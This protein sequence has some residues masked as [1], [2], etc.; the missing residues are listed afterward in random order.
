MTATPNPTPRPAVTEADR[1]KARPAFRQALEFW[2]DGKHEQARGMVDLG[3]LALGRRLPEDRTDERLAEFTDRVTLSHDERFLVL[4]DRE[5]L[6]VAE[7]STGFVLGLR[8]HDF[9]GTTVSP[10]VSPKGTYVVAPTA[11]GFLVYETRGLLPMS[12]VLTRYD[13]PLAF[14]DERHVVTVRLGKAEIPTAPSLEPR[15]HVLRE[16]TPESPRPLDAPAGPL[17]G[18]QA[19]DELIVVDITSGKIEKTLKLTMPPDQGLLRRVAA[20]PKGELC[21]DAQD[22]DRFAFNP[23]PIGRRVVRLQIQA[24]VISAIWRGGSVSLHRVR[25][26]KLL[27]SFR[28]RGENWKPGLVAVIA[29]PPRAAVATSLPEVGRGVEPPFSVTA[30]VDLERGRVIQLM[31]DCRWATGLSFSLDGK[32]LMVGDLRKACLHDARTGKLLDTTEEVRPAHG[33]PDEHADVEV[34]PLQEGRW[35]LRTADGSFGVF[36]GKS[37]KAL[38]RGRDDGN[39]GGY[40]AADPGTLYVTDRSGTTAELVTLG[41]AGIARRVLRP[42]ELEQREFPAEARNTPEGR[43]AALLE[44]LVKRSCLVEGFRLPLELCEASAP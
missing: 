1:V 18:E 23:V 30:L 4:G 27:G 26:Q 40:V 3:L 31:D 15:V 25:D 44:S 21:D 35:I 5:T 20:L 22:C 17:V 7:A 8:A 42:E 6:Y 13:A 36:D 34:K 32:R 12:E 9:G 24:G 19:D 16:L 33:H 38:F 28:P 11:R 2:S 14:L 29:D 10:E 41:G 39:A 43:R 37:G